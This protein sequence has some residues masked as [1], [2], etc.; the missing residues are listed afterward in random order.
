M[1]R[2]NQR[3]QAVVWFMAT[4]AACCSV[5]ALVYNVGAMTNKKEQTTNAADA[6]AISGAMMEARVLNYEAYANRA[7]VANEVTIAQLVSLDSW[8]QYD[9]WLAQWVAN[10]SSWIPGVNAFTSSLAQAAN[11]A[12]N[13]VNYFVKASVPVIEGFNRGLLAVREAAHYAGGKAANEAAKG[14]AEANLTNIDNRYDEAPELVMS[15]YATSLNYVR[16]FDFTDPYTG[17]GRA[18]AREVVLNARDAFSSNRPVGSFFGGINTV[19]EILGLGIDYFE[20]KKTSGTSMLEGYDHWSAQ[21]S[22][23][24]YHH[25][26]VVGGYRHAPLGY[27]RA[28]AGSGDGS[29]LCNDTEFSFIEFKQVPTVNCQLAQLLGGNQISW[30]GLPSFR[31]LA[32]GLKKNSPCAQKNGSDSPTLA[33]LAAVQRKRKATMSTEDLGMYNVDVQGPQ[34]S[35]RM[36]SD[37]QNN[38]QLTAISAACVFFLRPDAN[39]TGAME[40]RRSDGKHEYASLYNPYWQARITNA[41]EDWTD[42]LYTQIGN[43]GLNRATK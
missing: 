27:G 5:F 11:A 29:N 19:L 24:L 31:D 41:G 1:N 2:K 3:G 43:L 6:A 26:P 18:A 21:D 32:Q 9:Y 22:L 36:V 42:A 33:F 8:V 7:M 16:W 23:D 25:I 34:G 28:D 30:M 20:F 13:G 37:L 12:S 40:L 10:Y 39:D 17:N 35:P 4:V 14:V 38:N 15:P